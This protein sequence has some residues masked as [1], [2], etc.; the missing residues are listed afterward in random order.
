MGRRKY[1]TPEERHSWIEQMNA[2]ME[3]SQLEQLRR[4]INTVTGHII[5]MEGTLLPHFVV[6]VRPYFDKTRFTKAGAE[7][8]ARRLIEKR[9]RELKA[10]LRSRL[11]TEEIR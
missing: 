6:R 10:E 4:S 11:N 8:T 9:R 2:D 1:R 3:R 7:R 5:P